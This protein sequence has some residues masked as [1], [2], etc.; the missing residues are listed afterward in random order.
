MQKISP[1]A[2][3]VEWIFAN[4]PWQKLVQLSVEDDVFNGRSVEIRGQKLLNF[5]NGSYLGL[6]ADERLKV[7]A[8]EA[9]GR[10]GVQFP[11]S[12]AYLS[13][14]L[15][16]E[17]E[18]LL[19]QVFGHKTIVAPST[20]LAHLAVIPLFMTSD[21]III[22]DHK[23]HASL[24]TV[25]QTAKA[26]GARVEMIHHNDMD[27]LESKIKDFQ[28]TNTRIWFVTDGVFSMFGD[29]APFEDL[30]NL[31]TRYEQLWLYIDDA[32]GMSW[33]GKNG[34]G[35][36]LEKMDL[37]PRTIIATS[38]NKGFG[39]GGG[40]II[41]PDDYSKTL[42]RR[43]GPSLVFSGPLHPAELG[44]SIESAKIHLTPELH[45]RQKKVLQNIKQFIVTANQL[46]LPI[47]DETLSPIFFLACSKISVASK[48]CMKMQE[49][50][51][52]VN[53]ALF[54]AVPVKNSGVR[55]SIGWHL[56]PPDIVHL[57]NRIANCLPEILKEEDWD[58]P[59][60]R[61]TFKLPSSSVFESKWQES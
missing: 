48:V 34:R 28:H 7:G 5:G 11:S 56:N 27:E 36:V 22:V 2:T 58:I 54:P 50:G 47:A 53:P 45:S 10:Y 32:H 1:Y 26:S 43:A 25:I 13:I 44:A 60:I 51:F 46:G 33:T 55:I 29:H 9:I 57:L 23:A 12:R 18:A 35:M 17:L 4:F 14:P 42:L 52:L 31:M 61:K 15:Y 16:E 6:H 37:S 24:Q 19:E 21:D 20:T 59:H 49:E 8:M 40:A 30:Q 39:A 38:L 41:V 3:Q